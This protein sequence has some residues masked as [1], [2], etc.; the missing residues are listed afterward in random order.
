MKKLIEKFKSL[1]TAIS[2]PLI[3]VFIGT[4]IPVSIS[5][6]ENISKYFIVSSY[7]IMLFVLALFT[8]RLI[9]QG[10]KENTTN[11]IEKKLVNNLD[12]K[13]VYL[14]DY[15]NSQHL[16]REI[17]KTDEKTVYYIFYNQTQRE[18]LMQEIRLT[19]TKSRI[20][21]FCSNH[22]GKNLIDIGLGMYVGAI[23]SLYSPLEIRIYSEDNGYQSLIQ[24]AEDFGFYNLFIVSP[25]Q[26]S[27]V[28][29]KKQDGIYYNILK[30]STE[31]KMSLGN[32]KKKIRKSS[33]NLNPDEVNYIVKSLEERGKISIKDIDGIKQIELKK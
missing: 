10:N 15:E 18:R 2:L 12:G 3:V 27:K 29:I 22:T 16:P 9:L 30:N 8:R 19:S 26:S 21:H 24:I 11:V 23:Y 31:K 5:G 17:S 7:V 25:K 4:V 1:P 6:I 32:F 14:I 20:E 13:I 28:P 33:L